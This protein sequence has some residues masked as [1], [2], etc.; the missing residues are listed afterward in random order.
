APSPTTSATRSAIRAR[1]GFRPRSGISRTRAAPHRRPRSAR[2]RKQPPRPRPRSGHR[3]RRGTRTGSSVDRRG[4][5][6]TA[7]SGLAAL[8]VLPA[9]RARGEPSEV[10]AALTHPTPESRAELLRVVKEAL[11]DPPLTLADDAL[12]RDGELVIERVVR[13]DAS[14]NPLSGRDTGR[15][16]RFRLVRRGE[17]C[18]LVHEGS[19]RRFTLSSATCAPRPSR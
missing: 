2:R 19:G 8:A 11:R 16:E 9:C 12:V 14:G 10:P 4:P 6:V 13:R 1:R 18:V 15:P 7:A 17:C 5:L 3:S